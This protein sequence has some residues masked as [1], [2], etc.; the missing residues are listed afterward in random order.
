MCSSRA[1]C[2]F[3][4]V[5]ECTHHHHYSTPNETRVLFLG[6]FLETFRG[7]YFGFDLTRRKIIIFRVE[8]TRKLSFGALRHVP[9]GI[10]LIFCMF[11]FPA[12]HP[13]SKFKV[14][15]C[16][17]VYQKTWV[18]VFIQRFFFMVV[19]HGRHGGGLIFMGCYF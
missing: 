8:K 2:G 19:R 1:G 12:P 13:K 9:N 15:I 4:A 11:F 17:A 16:I 3:R 7:S 14:R 10:K 5:L 6:S 18:S